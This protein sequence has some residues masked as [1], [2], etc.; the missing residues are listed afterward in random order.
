MDEK[1]I[2]LDISIESD[3]DDDGDLNGAEGLPGAKSKRKQI[4]Y[5]KMATFDN[6][7]EAHESLIQEGF[8]RHEH[9]DG[10]AGRKTFYRCGNVKQKSK[11]QC[12][13]KRMIFEDNTKVEFEVFE[14][15]TTHT[16]ANID[17]SEKVKFISKEMKRMVVSCHE[18]R[19]TPKYIIIHIDNLR[20]NDN[21]FL[22]ESTP[23]VQQIHYIIR[24]HKESHNPK[25]L[26]LGELIDW[27][28]KNMAV[29]DDEDEPFVV[30]FEHSSEEG[31]LDFKIV[32]ST[33]RLL[34]HCANEK[35]MCA[36]ATY[37]LN[38]NGFPFMVIGTVDRMRKFQPLCFA[39]CVGETTDDFRFIFQSMADSVKSIFQMDFEPNILICDASDAIYNAF[40]EVFPSASL[41]I[42]CYVHVLRNIEKHKEKYKKE[43]KKEIFADIEILHQAS[44]REEFEILSKLFLKKW[45]KKD[46]S[47]ADY[48]KT[49]WLGRH[50]NWYTAAG[51]STYTPSTN[52]SLEG[53]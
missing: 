8:K 22:N 44:T 9:K 42:M 28:E 1:S 21:L 7:A 45:S 47:F 53:L 17:K 51:A 25:M 2:P 27:C 13:A 14:S 35:Q 40:F 41:V 38:W 39:L 10:K 46:K 16:C 50:C 18:S 49:N 33:K 4:I 3:E 31:K 15:N 5:T 34:S 23:N 48:F 6:L 20:K 43:H 29:P 12:D 26:F 24:A 36:D 30:G 37:K 19:M 52:N 32:V 11:H